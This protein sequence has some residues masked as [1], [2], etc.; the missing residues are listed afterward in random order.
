MPSEPPN[1]CV[2]AKS[3][4]GTKADDARANM[5]LN[6]GRLVEGRRFK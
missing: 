3:K 1:N 5:V 2:K 4:I 6:T